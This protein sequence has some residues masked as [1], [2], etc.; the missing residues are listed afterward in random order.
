M[1]K[2]PLVLALVTCVI[3]A[4]A[5]GARADDC[6]SGQHYRMSGACADANDK[7]ATTQKS[8]NIQFRN[9]QGQMVTIKHA[10]SYAVRPQWA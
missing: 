6:R 5:D 1:Q 2:S 7:K 10:T 9:A 3:V 8:G 4:N